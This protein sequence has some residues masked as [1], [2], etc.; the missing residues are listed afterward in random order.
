MAAEAKDDSLGDEP[1][2]YLFGEDISDFYKDE[3]TFKGYLKKMESRASKVLSE[4]LESRLNKA[5]NFSDMTEKQLATLASLSENAERYEDMVVFMRHL[6]LKRLWKLNKMD[7]DEL[8]KLPMKPLNPS[9]SSGQA[10]AVVP[11]VLDT[12]TRN[13]FSVAYKNV[14]GA[15]RSSWRLLDK[16][17]D[18]ANEYRAKIAEEIKIFCLEIQFILKELAA[19]TE[20]ID[21]AKKKKDSDYK[22]PD[23]HI[24]YLKMKGDYYRY[25]REAFKD[26][27]FYQD[28]CKEN[29][30]LAMKKATE[31]LE[32]TDP[33]R[34]GLA[35]NFSVCHYEILQNEAAACKL[36]K[37][38][39]DEAIEKLDSLNDS[40][41]K[42][43]TLIMQ[44][45]RDN[46]T[47]WSSK[48]DPA[49]DQ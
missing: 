15:R 2:K 28:Q 22:I 20:R 7:D 9:L 35:L 3:D 33:T 12:A 24:F 48:E 29:Y 25:L 18:L 4:N 13:L 40:S 43:S 32:P 42:D 44:L 1:D 49:A 27:E 31:Q 47:I 6:V 26:N 41:Y 19:M 14:V 5:F 37:T 8:C 45:L 21:Q 10:Q 23:S 16:E 46:L 30:E 34:L 39:F 11:A 38:A 36:A 17:D